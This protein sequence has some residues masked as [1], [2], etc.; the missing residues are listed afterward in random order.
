M[1]RHLEIWLKDFAVRIPL[2]PE[3]QLTE[4]DRLTPIDS[5]AVPGGNP[6]FVPCPARPAKE[7]PMKRSLV[8]YALALEAWA[9]SRRTAPATALCRWKGESMYKIVQVTSKYLKYL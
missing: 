2:C 4:S 5:A 9:W 1:P 3:R 8:E 6:D 7:Y